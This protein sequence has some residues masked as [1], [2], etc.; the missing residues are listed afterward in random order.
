MD[1]H[2]LE[3]LIIQLDV[4]N[5]RSVLAEHEERL[6]S[7]SQVLGITPLGIEVVG[8]II[9]AL[10]VH[11]EDGFRLKSKGRD[12]AI[13]N[14]RVV[15]KIKDLLAALNGDCDVHLLPLI[16]L[17]QVEVKEEV[18]LRKNPHLYSLV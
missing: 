3:V 14:T 12:I 18:F 4:V 16:L 9:L 11:E 5:L 7:R 8:A 2:F 13:I 15:A 17:G 1:A 10:D 6:I